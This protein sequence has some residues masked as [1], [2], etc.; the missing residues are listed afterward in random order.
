MPD[1][2]L[3]DDKLN[4]THNSK[5]CGDPSII[6][7]QQTS[8]STSP[9]IVLEGSDLSSSSVTESKEA[10]PSNNDLLSIEQRLGDEI[11]VANEFVEKFREEGI[12]YKWLKSIGVDVPPTNVQTGN[13]KNISSITSTR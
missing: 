7:S 11:R 4:T 1:E 9:N 13:T 10:T 3:D 5:R 8:S 12:L 6:N 2:T